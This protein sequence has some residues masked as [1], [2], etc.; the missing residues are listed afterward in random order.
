MTA[1]VSIVITSFNQSA[2]IAEAIQSSL[3]QTVEDV[4]VVIVDDGSQD[5]S[6]NII[7]GFL[8]DSRV[9]FVRQSNEGPSAAFNA[10]LEN[11]S[12]EYIAWL[13]GDDVC[14]PDR[15]ERQLE[16]ISSTRADVVFCVPEI[17][18]AQGYALEN[19][20]FPVFSIKFSQKNLLE[21]L[22]TVGN[23]FCAPS[24][25]MSRRVFER[26][27]ILRR[28]LVQL[29]DFEYWIRC[30]I[31]GLVFHRDERAVIKYRRHEANLSSKS[32]A[33]ASS[34]EF[35]MIVGNALDNPDAAAA[36]RRASSHLLLPNSSNSA[37]LSTLD[38]VL[39]LLS[40]NNSQMKARGAVLA[41][42]S[43]EKEEF[44]MELRNASIS[45]PA[46]LS[47]SLSNLEV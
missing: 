44:R 12:G 28:G 13:G 1:R 4:E 6:V 45:F 37:S 35:A 22:L 34:C 30:A 18:D 9:R 47:A 11:A 40:N 5:D 14:M 27:G 10:G 7:E 33:F 15:I 43:M 24:A 2:Y 20:D 26:I 39:F 21:T 8:D 29:Q 19:K 16:L 38:K 32:G 42:Q 23:F 46:F 36:I 31:N 17:I 41:I 25:F 3:R